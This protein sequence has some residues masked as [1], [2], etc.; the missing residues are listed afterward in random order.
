[1]K[2]DET[3]ESELKQYLEL[4]PQAVR[5]QLQAIQIR[6]FPGPGQR[7]ET[8]N[9]VEVLLCYG[10]FR[11]VNPH[12]YGGGN[13]EKAPEA[14]QKLA[15]FF[16]RKT[17]SITSKMLNL[18]GSREHGSRWEPRLYATLVDQ[19]DLYTNLY[20]TILQVTR[21]MS[22]GEDV[23][24]DFLLALD[25]PALQEELLGQYELP[26]SPH[27]LLR[28]AQAQ[29]ELKRVDQV[30]QL[31]DRLTEK[32]V[33]QKVRLLQN[34]F[35][36]DVLQNCGYTCVFCGFAPQ[37]LG[38]QSGL[39]IASHIKPWAKSEPREQIDVRNG[40]A[41]CP[42]HDAAFDSGYLTLEDTYSII[43]ARILQESITRDQGVRSYFDDLL[44]DVIILPANARKPAIIYLEYHRLNIF[45]NVI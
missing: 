27:S 1:M 5:E 18:D 32:L 40:L 24:P 29:Y 38:R 42:M 12:R 7:Q 39:L 15:R 25:A 34:Y 22:I 3:G 19:P 28:E 21:D 31:G 13:I 41:A 11:L 8:F 14:V 2:Q 35:A 4:S 45:R 9:A 26:T 33:E 17:G 37:S 36:R 16:Q 20:R 23:V 44:N 10:L 43:K 30:Y 6:S